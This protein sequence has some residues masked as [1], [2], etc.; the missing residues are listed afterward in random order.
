MAVI[1]TLQ[2]KP[3][4]LETSR[5]GCKTLAKKFKPS[6]GAFLSLSGFP[7]GVLPWTAHAIIISLGN[8]PYIVF[9]LWTK[10]TG[11]K[12]SQH[13]TELE[14]RKQH[15]EEPLLLGLNP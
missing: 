15:E 11:G 3:R 1:G 13:Q 12:V 6:E 2:T 9:I 14:D 7:R 5:E 8:L 10:S 4:V